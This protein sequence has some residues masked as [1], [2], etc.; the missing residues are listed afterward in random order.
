MNAIEMWR[1]AGCG[2]WSHAMRRPILHQR[3]EPLDDEAD[4]LVWCGPFERFV[5]TADDPEPPSPSGRV[6]DVVPGSERF[7]GPDPNAGIEAI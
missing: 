4:R 2:K 5:A 3:V 7:T 6:G 1:C